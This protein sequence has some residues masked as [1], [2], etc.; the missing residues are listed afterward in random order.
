ML[1]KTIL[2]DR[3]LARGARMV[4]FAGWEMPLQYSGVIDEHLRTREAVAVFDTSHMDAFRVRGPAALDFLSRMVT[5]DLRA[6]ADGRCRY[7]FLLRD[8]GGV[9]DDLI[10]YRLA[11]D[12]WMLVVNAG[13]AAD[14]F[15]W[16]RRHL[17]DDGQVLLEDLRESQ[18]KLDVQGPAAL[19]TAMR[20]LETGLDDLRRFAF[21][22]LAH[23]GRGIIVSRTGYTGEDGCEI[24][25]PLDMLP[26]LWDRLLELGAAPAGLG[27][28]DTLRLEA[29]LPLHGHELTAG[30]TPLEAGL[31]RHASKSE[32]FVGRDALLARAA[33]GLTRRLAPFTLDGRQTAR[34]G[35][36]VLDENGA[37]AGHVTSGS[38]APS[39]GHAIG[40]AL[41]KPPLAE[42]GRLWRVDTG[43][44]LLAARATTAPFYKRKRD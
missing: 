24:Y 20:L 15:R 8:D 1:R 41:V 35:Q 33:A 10:A 19:E 44:R 36:R 3:H 42:P 43:R 16:L 40:F 37:E 6:M 11:A 30:I 17:P 39:L 7:G 14:D 23:Q 21:R 12:D 25:A 32:P 28:R 18:G 5:A 27:A 26:A 29:G 9:L 2:H 34:H 31:M 13:P 38:Y 22:R 4:P